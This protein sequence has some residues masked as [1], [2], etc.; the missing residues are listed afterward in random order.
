MLLLLIN[1]SGFPED[2]CLIFAACK[3]WD[4]GIAQHLERLAQD[5]KIWSSSFSNAVPFARMSSSYNSNQ[6]RSNKPHAD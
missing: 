6:Y 2:E 4:S 3:M 5:Q 1:L